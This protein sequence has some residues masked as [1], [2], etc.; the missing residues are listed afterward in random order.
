M[1]G[2]YLTALLVAVFGYVYPVYL[3]FKVRVA[4]RPSF[5]AA[6]L[7]SLVTPQ[8]RSPRLF[9]RNVA[10]EARAL[11]VPPLA[12]ALWFFSPSPLYA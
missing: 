4:P 12:H 11:L 3:T 5:R 1:L 2:E 9:P 7:A 8:A 6:F 10:S